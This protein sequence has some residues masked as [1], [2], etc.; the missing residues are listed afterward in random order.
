MKLSFINIIFTFLIRLCLLHVLMIFMNISHCY[1]QND[2]THYWEY[3]LEKLRQTEIT[4]A[5][6]YNQKSFE[7]PATVKII[8]AVEIKERGY[9]TLDD[10]LADLPGFQFRNIQGF[11]SYVFMRG[12]PNQNNYIILMIDGV[13]INEINSGGF[14]GGAQYNL[15][16]IKQVE[17]IYGPASAIYGTNAVSGVI[18]IITNEPENN[19]KMNINTSFGS[20]NT[21][22]FDGNYSYYDPLKQ[23]GFSI[24]GMYKSSDKLKLG[25]ETG[26]NNWSDSMENF[27][28]D[29]SFDAKFK[30]KKFTTGI[31]YIN[32][33][34]SRTTNYKSTG[35][36][37]ADE[38][39][40]WNIRF[41]NAWTSLSH[42][43]SEK[44]KF[45]G[46]VYFRESTVLKNSVSY[47][48]KADS[49]SNG[50][51]EGAFRP[52]FNTG[53][54]LQLNYFPIEKL[55]IIGG[56]NMEYEEISDGFGVSHS[57]SQSVLPEYPNRP[58]ILNNTLGSIFFVGTYNLLKKLNFTA[59][60]RYDY[61]SVYKSVL[62]PRFGI[63][64]TFE[65]LTLKASYAE[66][67]RAPKNWDYTYGNGNP[68]LMPEKMQAV[69]ISANYCF[70]KNLETDAAIFYNNLFNG[71]VRNN[72]LNIWENQSKINVYGA[73]W[74]IRYSILNF[75]FSGNY[76]YTKSL[77]NKNNQI[78]EIAEHSFNA[79]ALYWITK[80]IGGEIKCNY[81]GKRK[82]NVVISETGKNYVDP[83]F[84]LNTSLIFQNIRNFDFAIGINNLL[85]QKYYHTS[86]TSVQRYRQPGKHFFI[87]MTFHPE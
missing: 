85:D 32:K 64:S 82:N 76:S 59:G 13:Q 26:D 8:T 75:R 39:S 20:F 66:A 27:E 18:N 42:D 45:T 56:T 35:T 34:A 65:K 10:V 40:L 9:F 24:A 17:I 71:L 6:K 83:A 52:N 48:L 30:Y 33:Q 36:N 63:V 7:V 54:E 51:Q 21:F 49:L 84:I 28:T 19:K 58:S 23:T 3:S 80:K 15:N 74:S 47:V 5:S 78:P 62:T 38:G 77:D 73:E 41:L 69:E 60:I 31:N 67:F 16:N 46:K 86:N 43:F 68:E 25:G 4:T 61:S 57:F 53:V 12:I 1:A 37:Y 29:N 44:T 55:K 79:G 11:N 50:D 72:A 22:S 2:S 70:T 14:Y 87:K 81:F